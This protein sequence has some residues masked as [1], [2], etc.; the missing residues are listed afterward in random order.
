LFYLIL[1]DLKW[2]VLE[3]DGIVHHHCSY[4][5]FIINAHALLVIILINVN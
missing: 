2:L 4:L 1:W 3:I 5:L